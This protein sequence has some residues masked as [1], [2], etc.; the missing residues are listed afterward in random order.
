M[1]KILSALAV[2]LSLLLAGCGADTPIASGDSL[3]D[4]SA[5]ITAPVSE[6]STAT[7]PFI[8][9]APPA[10]TAPLS[11]ETFPIPVVGGGDSIDY[12]PVEGQPQLK[13]ITE[14]PYS[15]MLSN[16]SYWDRFMMVNFYYSNEAG[17]DGQ[18]EGTC[19]EWTDLLIIDLVTGEITV[20]YRLDGSVTAGFLGN[21]HIYTYEYNPLSVKVFDR[22]GK[23]TVCYAA[24][25]G[26]SVVIGPAEN[27]VAWID[28]WESKTVE[29]ISLDTGEIQTYSLAEFDSS[30][31]QMAIGGSAFVSVYDDNGNS[32]IY[33]LTAD[34]NHERISLLDGYYS[35]GDA[36]LR[37]VNGV[38]RYVDLLHEAE[39]IGYFKVDEENASVIAADNN[40]FC[41]QWYDFEQEEAECRL[42]LCLPSS[43][44]RTELNIGE[45]FVCGQCW[46]D[47]A[48]YLFIDEGGALSLYIWEYSDAPYELLETGIHTVTEMERQNR[49]YA[50][51]LEEKWDISICY[52]EE[53]TALMP[54]DYNATILTDTQVISQKLRELSDIL[55][56][57]PGGF[58]TELPY[59]DYDHFEISLCAGLSPTGSEGINTAI[60]ISNTRG[61]VLMTV[62]DVVNSDFFEQT[63]AHE[64]FHLMERRIDQIDPSLLEGWSSLTPGG[65]GAYY[66]SYHDENG[67]EIND[68]SNTWYGEFDAELVY[69]VDAY[70]KSYPTEDRA[71]IFEYLVGNDGDPFFSDSPVLMAKAERLCEIVRLTFP[72][73]AAADE[74]AWEGNFLQEVP[75]I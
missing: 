68:V 48:L 57:Y 35:T 65:D 38:W 58:F 72:S 61:S 17:F 1:K 60:A 27:G 73:V 20:N 67:V 12:I 74:V 16:V 25:E 31:I 32:N 26:G 19:E 6:I 5:A 47:D 62:F 39:R 41:M 56:S 3:S 33:R 75:L 43:G 46:S 2:I 30:Y 69:F 54:Y 71:R 28:S 40:R 50:D 11:D 15:G 9:T 22:E 66:F 21:G 59:G 24:E 51:A 14:L 8:T 70:S 53:V 55:D 45:Q 7:A 18:E 29:R 64:L 4:T 63:F 10:T 52:G 42:I 34:G 37:E 44:R 49:A 23:M 36:L 13:K